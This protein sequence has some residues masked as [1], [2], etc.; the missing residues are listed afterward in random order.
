MEDKIKA[1]TFGSLHSDLFFDKSV[2]ISFDTVEYDK[3]QDVKVLVQLE[4]PSII[5]HIGNIINSRDN[6]DLIEP[7][8]CLR[9][10]L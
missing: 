8:I 3:S 5:D 6:F 4:P 1:L 10:N 9:K 7:I 2:S